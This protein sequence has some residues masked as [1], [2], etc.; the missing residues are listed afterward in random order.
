MRKQLETAREIA[1]TLD[2]DLVEAIEGLA[3][4][5]GVNRAKVIETALREN[6]TI[7]GYLRAIRSEP[8]KDPLVAP[9]QSS[10]EF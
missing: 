5:R 2:R 9:N 8:V 7:A 1:V 4:A 6:K 10:E 3:L